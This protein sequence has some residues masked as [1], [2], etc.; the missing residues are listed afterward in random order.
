MAL[1]RFFSLDL[2]GHIVRTHEQDCVHE[3]DIRATAMHFLETSGDNVV[4]V[5]VEA[6]SGTKL[7]MRVGPRKP[8][9]EST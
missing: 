5:D 1:Y 8:I 4:D 2:Y 9:A 3:D 7:V 6:W